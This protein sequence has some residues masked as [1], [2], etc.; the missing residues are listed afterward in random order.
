MPVLAESG[1]KHAR[2]LV[3]NQRTTDGFA[4]PSCLARAPVWA[5]LLRFLLLAPH[6]LELL[7]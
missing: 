1:N 3:S 4:L 5:A 7:Y 2:P 6:L